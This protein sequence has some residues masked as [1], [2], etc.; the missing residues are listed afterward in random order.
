MRWRIPT[1]RWMIARS[2]V[3]VLI[4]FIIAA[5]LYPQY[6]VW[7]ILGALALSFLLVVTM[8]LIW[9]SL[10]PRLRDSGFRW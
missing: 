7:I 6:L 9:R 10:G 5:V 3:G 4:A 2:L 8:V 1:W